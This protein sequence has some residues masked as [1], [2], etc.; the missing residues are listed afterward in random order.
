MPIWEII[1]WV[2]SILV[3]V[4]LMIPSVRKF[5]ILNLTGSLIATAYNVFFEIWPYAV[6]NAAIV[7]INVYWLWRL[8]RLGRSQE[9]DDAGYALVEAGE[10]DPVVARF[11]ERN[12]DEISKAYPGFSGELLDGAH[13]YLLLY[14]EEIIGLFAFAAPEDGRARILMDF[15]T[16]R[17]RDLTPGLYLYHARD[18][19]VAAGVNMVE[20]SREFTSDPGY[21]K[22]LGFAEQDA[23]LVRTVA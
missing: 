9:S 21:F 16:V 23:L 3:V 19:F 1:G 8:W 17:F 7:L 12:H 4:S 10:R 18:V 14:R 5:R 22:K 6:M 2:G 15:V 11:L 20:V 13:V